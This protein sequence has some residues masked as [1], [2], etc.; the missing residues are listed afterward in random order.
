MPTTSDT[1]AVRNAFTSERG[2][3]QATVDSDGTV[4]VWD[5]IAGHF[6]INHSLTPRQIARARREAGWQPSRTVRISVEPVGQNFGCHGVLKARN[7]HVL[8]TGPTRPHGFNDAA[9]ADAEQEVK[10]RGWTVAV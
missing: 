7:G 10:A 4:R 6:T 5:D 9:L 3:Y 8:W 1:V 2:I